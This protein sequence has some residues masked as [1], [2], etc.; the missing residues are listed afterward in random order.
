MNRLNVM[1]WNAQGI[2]NPTAIYQLEY[3][4]NQK[5]ID[6]IFINETFLKQNHKFKMANYNVYRH[7]RLSHG[8]GVLIAIKNTIQHQYVSTIS[9]ANI[10][11]VSII[12][13]INN[14]PIRF[15]SAYCPR[16]SSSFIDDINKITSTTSEFFIFGDF[17][18]HHTSW[19]CQGNNTAGR[20]LYSHQLSSSY[21]IHSS[22]TFTRFGQ[23]STTTQ[24]SVIDL[25]L[26]NSTLNIS[27]IETH[28]GLLN[29]DHVPVTCQIYGSIVQR[30]ALVPLYHLAN[31]KAINKW[32]DNEIRRNSLSSAIITESNIESILDKITQITQEAAKKVPVKEKQVWQRKISQITLYLIGQRKRY[33]RKL[34]R[35]NNVSDR[36]YLISVLKQLNILINYH[37]ANDRNDN[38]NKFIQRLP[39]GNKKF[40]QL[41]RVIRGNKSG[42]G[43]LAIDG[44]E[45]H[46][47]ER[48]AN[49]IADVFERSHQITDNLPSSA[50]RMV[51]KHTHW[52]DLQPIPESVTD[53]M[54]TAEEVKFFINK[55]RNKK[56]PGIDGIKPIILKKMS[57]EFV[58]IVTKIFNWCLKHGYFP[59]QFKIAKVIPI[60]KPGKDKKSPQSYRPISMLNGLD[61]IFENIILNRLNEFTEQN[62]ILSKEQFGFRR[63]HSTI[64]QVKRLVNIITTNKNYRKSTG[65]VFLDIEKAFD[66]IWHNGI[67]FKLNKFGYPIYLQKIIKSFLS[68][69]Y[70]VVNVDTEKSTKRPIPAG[71]PQGSILSPTLYSIYTSDFK[72]LRNQTA[73]FYADDTALI[74]SGKLS[75]AIVKNMKN[76]LIHA[77]KYFNKWKIKINQGK[78]QATIFPFNKSPKRNPQITLCMQGTEIPLLDAVKY[79]GVV[80]DKKLTFKQHV[81][82]AG[83]KAL[84][85][86]RALFPLLNRKSKLNRKNKILLYRMCIRPIMTYGCQ[87]WSTKC[88]KTYLKKLQIIQNKNLKI[89]FNLRRRFST[90]LLHTN[91]KQELLKHVFDKITTRFEDRNRSSRFD[92]IRNL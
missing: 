74:T 82:Q 7:D 59:K 21:Y 91:Y 19:N 67:I 72:A 18:A 80:L 23:R 36:P 38:W 86:G 9:T 45:V 55:Q 75:N 79:L 33:V 52:L 41:N 4:I 47:N 62:S 25:L 31:W 17:N 28:P 69:R 73:A 78:T 51:S 48:K 77:E 61:K 84:K 90:A 87:V 89:I 26:T 43:V 6:V 11:N 44:A 34:Q 30:K 10:E 88:A 81:F 70:F 2:T 16:Y 50:D 42:V 68:E 39:P 56:A 32:V 24:A 57:N 12:I 27:R 37:V 54:T 64:H 35:T 15:T 58:S 1:L 20:K 60:V 92:L 8:G 5:A 71:V 22:S 76:A 85:C 14:R 49:I 66:S 65:I 53:V 46:N 13:Y 3:I 83:D 40:W 29:S 63:D